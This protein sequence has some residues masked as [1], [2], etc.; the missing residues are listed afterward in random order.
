MGE[1]ILITILIHNL[2]A[3]R[4]HWNLHIFILECMSKQ[5]VWHRLV[6]IDPF[7]AYETLTIRNSQN[8]ALLRYLASSL[9]RQGIV[10]VSSCEL[11]VL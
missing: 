8:T 3:L 6:S 10:R 9:N 2:I 4:I 11:D 5:A 7:L 1:N